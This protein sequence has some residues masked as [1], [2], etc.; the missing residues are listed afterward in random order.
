MTNM[1]LILNML[2]EA[3]TTEISKEV[4]PKTL[5]AITL[6]VAQSSSKEKD[7]IIDLIMNMLIDMQKC[8]LSIIREIS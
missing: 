5:V 1:E 6:F 8:S 2:A 4:E 7:V 3:T